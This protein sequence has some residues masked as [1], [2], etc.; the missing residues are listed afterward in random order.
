MSRGPRL[1][2][3]DGGDAT[4]R[5]A[6]ELED[7]SKRTCD[8]HELLTFS[9]AKREALEFSKTV[10][11]SACVAVCVVNERSGFTTDRISWC[12]PGNLFIGCPDCGIVEVTPDV[13]DHGKPISAECG[14][15]KE[16]LY[17]G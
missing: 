8:G 6:I 12:K 2:Q 9:A 10:D 14:I 11:R 3:I 5:V 7:G 1:E 16:R 17:F 15:C 4:F 13:F